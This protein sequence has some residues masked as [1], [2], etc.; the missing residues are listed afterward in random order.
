MEPMTIAHDNPSFLLPP[1]LADRYSFL[2]EI[3]R[4]PSEVDWRQLLVEEI[5]SK[6]GFAGQAVLLNKVDAALWLALQLSNLNDGQ[7]V[8]YPINA[9]LS[10]AA[11]IEKIGGKLIFVDV[12]SDTLSLSPEEVNRVVDDAIFESRAV[13]K[14]IV[15]QHIAGKKASLPHLYNLA[16]RYGMSLISIETEAT[17]SL[18]EDP[19]Y[20][21][22]YRIMAIGEYAEG[23]AAT[24]VLLVCPSDDRWRKA[25][26]ILRQN[27]ENLYHRQG[28]QLIGALP[29]TSMQLLRGYSELLHRFEMES[30][31]KLLFDTY[32]ERLKNIDGLRL[33][34][35]RSTDISFNYLRLLL[36]VD[37]SLLHFSKEE[38]LLYLHEHG[39]EAK[40]MAEVL[41][42]ATFFP[43]KVCYTTGIAEI[44]HQRALSLPMGSALSIEE[45][46]RVCSVIYDMV[47][48]YN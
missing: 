12:E 43:S 41:H 3:T 24:G 21:A 4:T 32:A 38:L 46:E 5:L 13:P 27:G 25:K 19:I 9:P 37:D 20:P 23:I 8:I 40:P 44:W 18:M 15:L 7:E 30:K 47:A 31:R 33:F 1:L 17:S 6:T 11:T 10:G 22:H 36:F 48:H 39:I 2:A 29:A 26:S 16:E 34:S 28:Y 42:T 14:A 45:V 35:P